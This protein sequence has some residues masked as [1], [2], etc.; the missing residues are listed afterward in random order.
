MTGK[1]F[2]QMIRHA[3]I[4]RA[5][6]RLAAKHGLT[7]S[8]LA[9]RAGLDATA[10]NKSKRKGPSG[11]PRWPSTE[12]V[13][14]ILSC[15]GETM[16]SFITLLGDRAAAGAPRTLPLLG[17]TKAG[18]AGFFDDQGYP[19]GR[20][21]D[22]VE[23]PGIADARAYALKISGD[24]MKPLYRSGDIVVVSPQASLRAGDRVVVKTRGGEVMAKELV[25]QNAQRVELRSL[26][27]DHGD[28]T[29]PRADIQWMAR[30]I[31]AEQ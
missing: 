15:T 23:F 7:A 30:I 12:S 11:K 27:P 24:S 31:W 18:N 5:I 4:W 9:R 21:W 1:E 13:A 8:G 3:E 22:D 26:N 20:G 28:R 16:G 25:R 10:F 2:R 29:L 19:A 14:K 6:D 17:Y